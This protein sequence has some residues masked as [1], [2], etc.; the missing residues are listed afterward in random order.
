MARTLFD[1]GHLKG[2]KKIMKTLSPA[3]RLLLWA[4]TGIIVGAAVSAVVII[5]LRAD[6]LCF[7]IGIAALIVGLFAC[8]KGT[9]GS[10]GLSDKEGNTVYYNSTTAVDE[11]ASSKAMEKHYH[12]NHVVDVNAFGLCLIPAG[13][14]MAIL[15]HLSV[16]GT[17]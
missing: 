11:E 5:A 16:I 17:F 3:L 1:S 10:T 13:L 15:A 12:D 2:R 7:Y 6:E 4:L 9:P 14:V 8:L